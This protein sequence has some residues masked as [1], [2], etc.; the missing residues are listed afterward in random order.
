MRRRAK[1]SILDPKIVTFP[2]SGVR[3][4]SSIRIVVV[5]PEPFG[6]TNP[7]MSPGPISNEISRTTSRPPRFFHNP[8]ARTTEEFELDE[9]TGYDTVG[10]DTL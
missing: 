3:M 2:R 5:L 1:L 8:S 6:P 9:H 4:S 10:D 7:T